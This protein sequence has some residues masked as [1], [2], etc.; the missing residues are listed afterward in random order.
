MN[1]ILIAA[2]VS[3]IVSQFFKVSYGLFKYGREEKSRMLWRIVW[4][5]GMPSAH[6]AVITSTA[7]TI[8]FTSGVESS[9]FGLSAVM[10][11]IVIYDRGRMYSIYNTFQK[12]YPK[13]AQEIQK[14]PLLKD[15]VGHRISEILM[16]IFIGAGVGIILSIL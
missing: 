4:A 2:I 6:S 13:F 8:Y 5:G 11:L 7:V 14:A 3:W 9:I 15:L 12:K 10:S 1:S 16:G